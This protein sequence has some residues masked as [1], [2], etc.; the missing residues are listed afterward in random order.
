MALP[1]SGPLSFSEIATA[2]GTSAPY[3]LSDMSVAADF[4]MPPYG[5]NS[6]YGYEP[7]SAGYSYDSGTSLSWPST[8]GYTLYEGAWDG[9]DDAYTTS[10]IILPT[11]FFM[12]G[13]SSINLFVST[14]GYTTFD[15]GDGNIYS[16]PQTSEGYPSTMGGN[17]GDLYMIPGSLLTDG[18]TQNL[19]YQLNDAGSGKYNYKVLVLCGQYGDTSNPESYLINFYRDSSYQWMETRLKSNDAGGTV[20][21]YN[22]AGD[23]SQT[24]SNT[25]GLVWRGDLNGQNWV[26]QGFGRVV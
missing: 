15:F 22:A 10:D 3:S 23:V 2:V 26:Y 5:V 12:N 16:S 9:Q 25:T 8:A 17:L 11:T 21:P 13:V 1:S 7:P 20:G 14:N 24:P 4:S 18:D 6:F 19:W